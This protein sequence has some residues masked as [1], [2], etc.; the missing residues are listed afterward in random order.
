MF[1]EALEYIESLIVVDSLTDDKLTNMTL[2]HDDE[3][4][5]YCSPMIVY[6]LRDKQKNGLE[7]D[8]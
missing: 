4:I 5:S 8:I 2:F 3:K 6:T 7:K 1:Q